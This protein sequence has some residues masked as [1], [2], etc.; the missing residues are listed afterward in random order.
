MKKNSITRVEV[1]RRVQFLTTQREIEIRTITGSLCKFEVS[2]PEARLSKITTARCKLSVE[3]FYWFRTARIESFSIWQF[4]ND[5]NL[6]IFIEPIFMGETSA[7]WRNAR[8]QFQLVLVVIAERRR[9]EEAEEGWPGVN[10][11][12]H[13]ATKG[14]P[15]RY[16]SAW[17]T[18]EILFN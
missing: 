11:S 6:I 5:E 13:E 17:L 8:W 9:E 12:Q 1:T 4:S 3:S 18:K 15:G 10:S 16:L 7:R 2:R 14:N